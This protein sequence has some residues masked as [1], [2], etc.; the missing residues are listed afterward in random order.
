MDTTRSFTIFE[1]N[2]LTNKPDFRLALKRFRRSAD[3]GEDDDDDKN[4][5]VRRTPK[6]LFKAINHINNE[7]I[8]S[9]RK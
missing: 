6:A 7:I 9:D 4:M 1:I 8:D 2:K 3:R 5:N